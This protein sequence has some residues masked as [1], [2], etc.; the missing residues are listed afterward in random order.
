MLNQV[1]GA[2]NKLT[3]SLSLAVSLPTLLVG[4]ASTGPRFG[5]GNGDRVDRW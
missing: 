3:A 1:F 5:A 2:D 4:F